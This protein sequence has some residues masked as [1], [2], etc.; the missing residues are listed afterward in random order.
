M[1]IRTMSPKV[2]AVDEVGSERDMEAIRTGI[3]CGCAFL[4]TAHGKTIGDMLKK[5]F[6]KKMIAEGIFERF[7]LLDRTPEICTV[8]AILDDKLKDVYG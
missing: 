5:P 1:L 2:I 3:N 7:I 8:T 6:Y 4:G